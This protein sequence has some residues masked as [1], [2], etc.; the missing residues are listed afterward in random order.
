MGDR[1]VPVVRN[2]GE[3]TPKLHIMFNCI[4]IISLACA[5]CVLKILIV[6][7]YCHSLM[8]SNDQIIMRVSEILLH[9]Q[10]K[11]LS[12]LLLFKKIQFSRHNI[13][14]TLKN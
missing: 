4:Q 7:L 2:E 9:V 8:F 12:Y 10:S 5:G 11:E 14:L 6:L 3:T 1:K 13:L